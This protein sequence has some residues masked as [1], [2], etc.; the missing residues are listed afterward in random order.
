MLD[1]EISVWVK[2]AAC[3]RWSTLENSQ[4]F[5]EDSETH[6]KVKCFAHISV[7]S[8]YQVV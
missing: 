6:C 8:D 2:P 7:F 5:A 1:D 4:H 3:Q